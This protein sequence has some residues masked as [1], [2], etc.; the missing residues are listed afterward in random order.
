MKITKTQLRKL[1]KEEL[2]SVMQG[3]EAPTEEEMSDLEYNLKQLGIL[4][5]EGYADYKVLKEKYPESYRAA[6]KLAQ[7]PD[8]ETAD[9]IQKGLG[10]KG[11]FKYLMPLYILQYVHG[12][13]IE[14]SAKSGLEMIKTFTEPM[15]KYMDNIKY[16]SRSFGGKLLSNL[17]FGF[18]EE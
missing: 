1:I 8:A 9:A 4:F 5:K 10:I 7:Y 12:G 6:V 2:E 3:Q 15:K 16:Y 13:G 11:D 17:T 14:R 18:L